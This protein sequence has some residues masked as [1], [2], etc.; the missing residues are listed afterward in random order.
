[1]KD[2][3]YFSHDSN[4]S[5]DDK[6][7]ELRAA[8]GWQGY[9]IYWAI[10]ERLR[11][12]DQYQYPLKRINGLATWLVVPIDILKSILFD[13]DLF[14]ND[15]EYFW[16]NSLKNRMEIRD[17][18]NKKRSDAGKKSGEVRAKGTNYEQEM[19]TSLTSAEQ[20]FIKIGTSPEQGKEIERKLK[21]NIQEEEEEELIA[22]IF[23]HF[24]FPITK[25]QVK[26]FCAL[27]SGAAADFNKKDLL[28]RIILFIAN[29]KNKT[30]GNHGKNGNNGNKPIAG[31]FKP[32]ADLLAK[33]RELEG[34]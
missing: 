22:R 1:M 7:L 29:R 2:A 5:Q 31:K 13:F 9:G 25:I 24:Q 4:A 17:E 8:H 27:N 3:Y 10:I 26:E 30:N 20:V 23:E 32:V 6:I 34:I 19:N 14:Q 16:T 28:S 33:V 15:G 21:E 11:D 18:I 12:S